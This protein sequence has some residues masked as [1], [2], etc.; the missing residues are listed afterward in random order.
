MQTLSSE[1][2]SKIC[3]CGQYSNGGW[4][5]DPSTGYWIHKHHFLKGAPEPCGKPSRFSAIFECDTC[6]ELFFAP[7][8]EDIWECPSCK[9]S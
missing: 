3:N 1:L 2:E 6:D 4:S 5:R 7:T 9:E 8:P